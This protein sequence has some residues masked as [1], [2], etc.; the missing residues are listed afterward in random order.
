MS[1]LS[2]DTAVSTSQQVTVIS[3]IQLKPD[4]VF[5]QQTPVPERDHGL[6]QRRTQ[7]SKIDAEHTAGWP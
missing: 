4:G 7:T 5:G 6:L 2:H 3:S 1:S